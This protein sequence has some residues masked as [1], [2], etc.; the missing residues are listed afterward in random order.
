MPIVQ[1][2]LSSVLR[3][4]AQGTMS[5]RSLQELKLLA[6]CLDAMMN[7][8]FT[9]C[10]DLLMLRFQAVEMSHSDGHWHHAKH[11]VPLQEET[12]T[13]THSDLRRRLIRDEQREE[14]VRAVAGAARSRK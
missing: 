5:P 7:G 1:A 13:A 3:P 6:R 2:Y 11:L 8:D 12:V 10:V 4:A 14:R 9:Q